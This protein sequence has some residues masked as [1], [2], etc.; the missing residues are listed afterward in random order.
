MVGK[1][2]NEEPLAEEPLDYDKMATE[3]IERYEVEVGG[4]SG[5]SY[6]G[7]SL[8][9]SIDSGGSKSDI[10]AILSQL[11]PRY[12]DKRIQEF[13]DS[14]TV[15]RVFPDSFN[16]KHYLLTMSYIEENQDDTDIDIAMAI[17]GFQDLLTR[18][19]NG[20]ERQELLEL[21]GL[22]HDEQMAE[23]ER[24]LGVG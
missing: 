5:G 20:R 16:D 3:D 2:N 14:V 1:E 12:T 15:S 8:S 10:Q 13:A 19:Y 21:G 9:E 7:G 24:Q 11:R 4:D 18:A 17:S 22:A 6:G 23:I